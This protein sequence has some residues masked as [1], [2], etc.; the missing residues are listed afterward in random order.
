MILS[1]SY[2]LRSTNIII[3]SFLLDILIVDLGRS[4]ILAQVTKTIGCSCDCETWYY[5]GD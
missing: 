2:Y 4:I 1:N 3:R 5:F